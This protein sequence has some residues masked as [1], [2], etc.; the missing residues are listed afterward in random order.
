MLSRGA[1]L[2]PGKEEE[3]EMQIVGSWS[4]INERRK[5]PPMKFHRPTRDEEE[6]KERKEQCNRKSPCT[7]KIY[8]FLHLNSNI[9]DVEQQQQLRRRKREGGG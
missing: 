3:E 4:G 2:W 7:L 8:C 6:E 5:S 1:I 9:D